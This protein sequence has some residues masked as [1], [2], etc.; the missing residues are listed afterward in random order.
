VRPKPEFGTIEIRVCDTPLDIDTAAA[1]AAFA[2]A[3]CAWLLEVASD[4]HRAEE[5]H[6][7]DY[8]RFQ[9]SRFGFG[10]RIADVRSGRPVSLRDDILGVLEAL[11]K[12]AERLGSSAALELL[13]RRAEAQVNDA[14]WMRTRK[15]SDGSLA[16]VVRAMCGRWAGVQGVRAR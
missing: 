16:D 7:Y 13:W 6:V 15:L 1:L 10:A 8:N 12:Y 2:Q 3:L 14:Q 9:A 5:Y 4:R 11:G